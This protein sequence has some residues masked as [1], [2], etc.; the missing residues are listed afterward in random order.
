M[1]GFA[2]GTAC[3][4]ALFVT[5]FRGGCGR[6]RFGGRHHRRRH[7]RWRRHL[8]GRLFERLDTS[9][10]Q[11]KEI[12]A[13][14]EEVFETARGMKEEVRATRSEVATSLRGDGFDA[15]QLGALF[16]RQ[17]DQLRELQKAFAG[18]LGRVHAALEPGQRE[19]LARWLERR[20]FGPGFGG[21]YRA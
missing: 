15:E 10:A 13:A 20:G 2:F 17:D 14:L 3:L 21:P 18:G 4:I 19:I 7:G 9:P 5:M 1:F 12:G 16:S 6:H 11:E 8:L